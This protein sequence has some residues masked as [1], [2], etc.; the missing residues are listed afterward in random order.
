MRHLGRMKNPGIRTNRNSACAV[1][2]GPVANVL[3]IAQTLHAHTK[4]C[5]VCTSLEQT[6]H[7]WPPHHL[8]PSA[9]IAEPLHRWTVS[10]IK[11]YSMRLSVGCVGRR[12]GILFEYYLPDMRRINADDRWRYAF[13]YTCGTSH[14]SDKFHG[15][16]SPDYV[17]C[18]YCSIALFVS[19]A[20]AMLYRIAVHRNIKRPAG[21]GRVIWLATNTCRNTTNCSSNKSEKQNLSVYL[22][23]I[24]HIRDLVIDQFCY[25]NH[26]AFAITPTA[27]F[28]PDRSRQLSIPPCPSID[29]LRI[30]VRCP[31]VAAKLAYHTHIRCRV[32]K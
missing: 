14:C 9:Y 25:S 7:K 26:F 8:H 24:N 13:D 15:C 5:F 18:K 28:P 4:C 11:L 22:Y 16:V 23:E 31:S 17:L 30:S 12:V 6:L 20:S 1:R 21:F 29:Q 32:R 3:R 2:F 10:I 27:P 19:L